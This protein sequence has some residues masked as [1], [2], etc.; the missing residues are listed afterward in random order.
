[1][2]QAAP[3]DMDEATTDFAHL[4]ATDSQAMTNADQDY[5]AGIDR[6][7][8]QDFI[9]RWTLNIGEFD[10]TPSVTEADAL[11]VATFRSGGD[12]NNFVEYDYDVITNGIT[13]GDIITLDAPAVNFP[14]GSGVGSTMTITIDLRDL[15]GPIDTAGDKTVDLATLASSVSLVAT[16]DI[17]TIVDVNSDPPR[18]EYTV[19]TI[20]GPPDDGDSLEIA[21]TFLEIVTIDPGVVDPDGLVDYNADTGFASGP[22][23]FIITITGDFTGLEP[24]EFCYDLDDNSTGAT[25]GCDAG[26]PQR[27]IYDC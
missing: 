13:A 8:S 27:N 21:R 24:D 7:I 22:D 16:T 25:V 12:G 3:G 9:A 14:A 15:F 11:H 23:S 1:M 4:A 2:A 17:L 18:T 19:G 20:V 10:G 5:L 26:P 6:T